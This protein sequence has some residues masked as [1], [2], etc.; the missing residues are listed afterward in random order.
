MT[1]TT[2]NHDRHEENDDTGRMSI[3]AD[4]PT[5]VPEAPTCEVPSQPSQDDATIERNTPRSRTSGPRHGDG[6]R[7]TAGPSAGISDAEPVA[8]KPPAAIKPAAARTAQASPAPDLQ[9]LPDMRENAAEHNPSSTSRDEFTTVYDILDGLETMLSQA[10]T[11]L[12]TPGVVKVDREEFTGRLAELKQRLP[13]QLERASALMREAERRLDAARTQADAIIAAA[14][15][16]ASDTIRDAK[17]QA[18]YLAGQENVTAIAHQQ[19]STILDQANSRAAHLTHGADEYSTK[20][21]EGL[22]DE[23]N[24]LQHDV[25]AGL[26]VLYDRRRQAAQHMAEQTAQPDAQHPDQTSTKER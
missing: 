2:T 8:E 20:V 25:Q 6:G 5:A 17:E 21:M 16:R 18:Q 23:L 1:D 15:S 12:F 9:S 24:K 11:G 4:V 3:P 19:A 13:V 26:H 10:K 22:A 7:S 14:H